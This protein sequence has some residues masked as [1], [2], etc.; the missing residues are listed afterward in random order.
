MAC[1]CLTASNTPY[2]HQ[3]K[4]KRF[5]VGC[6]TV[7]DSASILPFRFHLYLL[8][9]SSLI[10][11][12]HRFCLINIYA[13]SHIISFAFSVPYAWKALPTFS[14]D[15]LLVLPKVLVHEPFLEDPNWIG[16]F[17]LNHNSLPHLVP[18]SQ[19]YCKVRISVSFVQQCILNTY[20]NNGRLVYPQ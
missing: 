16:I 3:Q 6:K 10:L 12:P 8:F 1:T 20:N 5:T 13:L 2:F 17:N 4:F 9:S 15:Y 7:Q 14:R 11:R 19:Y 18:S